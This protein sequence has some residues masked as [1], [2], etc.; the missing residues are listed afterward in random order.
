LI[1]FPK[2]LFVFGDDNFNCKG[3]FYQLKISLYLNEASGHYGE[4][5][6]WNGS[7]KPKQAPEGFYLLVFR[8]ESQGL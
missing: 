6:F 1:L 3:I 4:H 5:W 2:R 7:E 8:E